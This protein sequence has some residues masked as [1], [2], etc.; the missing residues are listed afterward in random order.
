MVCCSHVSR[1][2]NESRLFFHLNQ[3]ITVSSFYD[4]PWK[5]LVGQFICYDYPRRR[6]SLFSIIGNI[7]SSYFRLFIP[8]SARQEWCYYSRQFAISSTLAWSRGHMHMSQTCQSP[9]GS[10]SD[11][12]ICA[13]AM[14]AFNI[15]LST[16]VSF[17]TT[18]FSAI[19]LT[20]SGD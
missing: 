20:Q 7:G 9:A 6:L 19:T 12:V 2:D 8:L 15:Q 3:Y 1:T 17:D 16:P 10:S 14:H 13:A 18:G 11:D 4:R 5:T